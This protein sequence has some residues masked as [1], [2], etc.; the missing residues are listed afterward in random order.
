MCYSSSGRFFTF[1][2]IFLFPVIYLEGQTVTT[3]SPDSSK[4]I[5]YQRLFHKLENRDSVSIFYK[6][7][8]FAGKTIDSAAAALS[9]EDAVSRIKR[10]NN[11]SC[12]VVDVHSLVFVP[13]QAAYYHVESY[14]PSD[15]LLIGNPNESGKF[16]TATLSGKIVDG[17]TGEPL[18]G[19]TVN[20]A[21]LGTGT[22]SNPKGEFSMNLPV[23][24]HTLKLSYIGYEENVSK[25]KLVSNGFAGFELFE[26]SVKMKELVITA[27][28]A[29]F[30]VTSTQMSLLR[31]NAKSI[32]ELP[33]SLGET[34]IL[35]SMAL[36][37]G[38]QNAGEFGTGFNVRGGSTDQNLILVED[39][40]LFNSSHLFGLTSAISADN[41]T[42]VTLLK[43]GIPARYGERAASVM[44][45]RLGKDNSDKLRIKGGIGLLDSRLSLQIP[46]GK[47]KATL[48]LS[49]RTSYS[50]WL[51]HKIPDYDLQNSTASFYDLDALYVLNLNARN[52]ITV[53]GYYSADKFAFTKNTNYSYSNLLSSFRWNH[54][55]GSRLSSSL[56]TGYS[57]Y[58]YNVNETDTVSPQSAYRIS[59][60]TRYNNLKWNF[61]WQP[62]T[63]H[64][65]D[66]GINAIL[67]RISPG[68]EDPYGPQS[69]IKPLN[70][71]QEMGLEMAAY[72][73][74]NFDIL[75][76]LNT[77]LGLRYVQYLS[78]G[79]AYVLT[80]VPGLP[81]SAETVSDT[82]K[83]GNNQLIH[84]Y[85]ALEP[86]IAFRYNLNEES[87][88]KWS[89]NRI[90]QFINLISNNSVMSPLDTWTLS[91]AY[92]R[93]LRCD[94]FAIGYFRNFVQNTYEISVEAYYKRLKNLI[95]ITNGAQVLMN[96][97][98]ETDLLDA[99][100]YGYGIEF[101]AKKNAGKL[102][103]WISYTY[104]QSQIQ[105]T[106]TFAAEQINRNQYYPSNFDKP[107][108]LVVNV[109][110]HLSRRWRVSGTFA[111]NTG[112]P[113]TLPELKYLFQG[114]QLIY[115]SDRNKYRL[116]DFHR[117]DIS[118]SYDENLKLKKVWKGSW[119]LSVI[120][121]YGR[122]NVYSVYYSR[123]DSRIYKSSGISGMNMLYIIGVPLPTLTYNFSF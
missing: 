101:Y 115:Y 122:K 63:R 16:T 76:G 81:R 5:S 41:V 17:R 91:N 15:A 46:L 52:K 85:S 69:L 102:T 77:E 60:M 43:A 98:I 53:F 30:N 92:V 88:V 65:V 87:S 68:E 106:G 33:A 67:Y 45:I 110:Y 70:V 44:D 32:R 118:I 18:Y 6:P 47:K 51:L 2:L 54:Q 104:S 78:L 95:E 29:E 71:Q 48:L 62:T 105:T 21:K 111:Y 25:I 84:R 56:L 24:E 35:R 7:E 97:H 10:L 103:G 34:D 93:P 1:C 19:A 39:V 22:L 58:R 14:G 117:L 113:T 27:E 73:S 94:Q 108:N 89:Y 112:R 121:V 107:H 50:N 55:Y 83:Y 64:S 12:I 8:W 123:Q 79:P 23:G 86:R 74:D 90:N 66:F 75:P 59:L 99:G 4:Y 109:N 28:R 80:Y 57:Q 120:N 96:E 119:T 72:V 114:K 100:G 9:L 116:P 20:E 3:S 26:K 37:P 82:L 31:L 36:L 11:L 38:I 49:G 40:P 42:S 13:F 61:N